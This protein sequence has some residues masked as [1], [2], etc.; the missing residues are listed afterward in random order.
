MKRGADGKNTS[1]VEWGLGF[2]TVRMLE[3]DLN[4][5]DEDSAFV[6]LKRVIASER[7]KENA[8]L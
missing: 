6:F 2:S 1:A 3:R 8:F 5:H 7:A 4:L